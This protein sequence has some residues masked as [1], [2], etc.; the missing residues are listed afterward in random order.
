MTKEDAL[1]KQY[2]ILAQTTSDVTG[3]RQSANNFYIA[4]TT[5]LVGIAAY[6]K[7]ISW[8]TSAS[9]C[10]IGMAICVV[11]EQNIKSYKNL[12]KAK[13]DVLQT[14]EK[15]LPHQI[16]AEEW[17]KYK[18]LQSK[19]IADLE[20]LMPIMFGLAYLIILAVLLIQF[21]TPKSTI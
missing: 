17:K 9:F 14:I 8:I 2:E 18:K 12:N 21:I 15:R 7:D 19:E 13:F 20:R 5:A 4:S 3:W 6:L 16:F 11:W 10:L 1:L